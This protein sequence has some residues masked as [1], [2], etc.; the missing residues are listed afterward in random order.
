M[1]SA[2]CLPSRLARQSRNPR[3]TGSFV[4]ALLAT[5][6]VG[7][8]LTPAPTAAQPAA[9]NPAAANG[10]AEGADDGAGS[11]ATRPDD[12]LGTVDARTPE[13][14]GQRGLDRGFND[15]S[16]ETPFDTELT[17]TSEAGERSLSARPRTR[18]LIDN[19]FV[20]FPLRVR[21]GLT[22]HLELFGTVEGYFDNPAR[23]PSKWGMNRFEPGFK[24]QWAH[25]P[26][27][28]WRLALGSSW[29]LPLGR[30]PEEIQDGFARVRPFAVVTR[31]GSWG[32]D[33]LPYVNLGAE[34]VHEPLGRRL[35]AGDKPR[36]RL[37]LQPGVLWSPAGPWRGVMEVRWRTDA[38][39][40][41]NQH[42]VSLRQGLAR[43]VPR[44]WLGAFG[45][46]G[47]AEVGLNL[48]MPVRGGGGLGTS[49]S[50]RYQFGDRE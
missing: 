11:V 5:C 41:G 47:R 3:A 37:T 9:G 20:R 23:S 48:D 44:S 22:D 28:D 2:I 30:P 8:A 1:R 18:D 27:S 31:P 15:E 43:E 25:P 29:E 34:L 12:A 24:W 33:L 14:G 36:H 35:P 4:G 17:G 10:N 6:V 38:I 26:G 40:G 16:I 13:R 50:A 32:P 45:L 19:P 39:D 7:L 49:V 42:Q 46:R 21:Y